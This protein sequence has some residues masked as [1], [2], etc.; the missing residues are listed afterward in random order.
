M[1]KTLA[2]WLSHLETA[3]SN[4]LIDMGL[5]RVGEVAKRIDVMAA[6]LTLGATL[7][8]LF[9]IDLAY[10]PPYSSPIDLVAVAANAAMSKLKK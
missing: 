1:N 2:Q 10:A 5:E 7:A 6:A 3:H 4:G 9:A 8:D